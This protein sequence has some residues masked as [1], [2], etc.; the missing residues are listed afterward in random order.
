M[1]I[2]SLILM[3]MLIFSCSSKQ[4]PVGN[5]TIIP[6]QTVVVAP[7][8]VVTPIPV[9][10]PTK[11]VTLW[12]TWYNAPT[13]TQDSNGIHVR[14]IKGH[15][16]GVKLSQKDWCNLAM[17]GTGF[18]DGKTYNYAGTTNAYKVKCSHS[19]SGR[20]KFYITNFPYGVGNRNNPLVPFYSVACDQSKYKFGTEFYI[21]EAVG[22]LLPD[23]TI[24]DGYFKCSDVGGLIENN[25]ID[26]FIGKAT[27]NPFSFV[28]SNENESFKAYIY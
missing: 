18:I 27:K 22:A 9:V 15:S 11:E 1:K 3:S 14:D 21:P 4:E 23:G 7:V 5:P 24:H 25:H 6:D 8:I 10:K 19:P 17:E 20:V 12:A 13:F 2:I 26:I 16:L 28:K